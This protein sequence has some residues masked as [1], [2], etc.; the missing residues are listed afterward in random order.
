VKAVYALGNER[1][2]Q[3]ANGSQQDR[4]VSQRLLGAPTSCHDLCLHGLESSRP[5]ALT[6][7]TALRPPKEYDFSK[8]RKAEPRYLRRVKQAVT[9]RL[10]P[11]V[12]AY[13]RKL[14]AVLA[15]DR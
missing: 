5:A 14:A 13:F 2:V 7:Q 6:P 3:P 15:T 8:L 4:R 9:M 11:T 1:S 12:V 10:D